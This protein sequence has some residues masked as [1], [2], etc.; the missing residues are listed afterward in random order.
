MMEIIAILLILYVS[1]EAN[2][3]HKVF[4][5]QEWD[6]FTRMH[7]MKIKAKGLPVVTI[8]LLMILLETKVKSGINLLNGMSLLQ[9]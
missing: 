1:F 6:T 2:H 8:P 7:P 5:Q 9:V 4:L 3:C